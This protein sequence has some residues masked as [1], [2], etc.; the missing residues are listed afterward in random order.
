M[1]VE[2]YIFKR[3]LRAHVLRYVISREH[4]IVHVLKGHAASQKPD[5]ARQ[6]KVQGAHSVRS[7]TLRDISISLNSRS[8]SSTFDSNIL[9]MQ[10]HYMKQSCCFLRKKRDSFIRK[11][12]HAVFG[13]QRPM[14]HPCR[15][16]FSVFH[17][18]IIEYMQAMVI[19]LCILCLISLA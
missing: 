5:W 12:V 8:P 3:V 9:L 2:D 14:L 1:Q 15:F 7:G 17:C 13:T 19:E 18:D 11:T 10:L 4:L 16:I 6:V